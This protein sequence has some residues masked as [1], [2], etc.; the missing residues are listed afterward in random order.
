[1]SGGVRGQQKGVSRYLDE[2]WVARNEKDLQEMSDGH[3][4]L[5]NL[6]LAEEE[7][8]ITAHK[9]HIDSMVGIIKGEMMILNEVDQ[10]GSDVD[11]YT[12][13]LKEYL[14]Q[15]VQ[16]IMGIKDKVEKFTQN[17][18]TEEEVSKKFYRF[19]SEILGIH[20]N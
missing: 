20:D 5:I 10:P 8:L 12:T 9:E 13:L 1:V 2:K 17:L 7:E 11:E 19:Q 14:D 3:E 15:Q 4:K 16:C 18:R 6:I